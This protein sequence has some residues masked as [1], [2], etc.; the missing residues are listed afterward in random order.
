MTPLFILTKQRPPGREGVVV[1]VK[2]KNKTKTLKCRGSR[3]SGGIWGVSRGL[4]LLSLVRENV[5]SSL[6]PQ[7]T[8]ASPASSAFQGFGFGFY[9]S[10]AFLLSDRLAFGGFGGRRLRRSG[11]TCL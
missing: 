6:Q 10:S 3:G 5:W 7:K 8:S 4:S 11:G 2:P 1:S 9:P